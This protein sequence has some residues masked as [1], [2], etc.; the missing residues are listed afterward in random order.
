MKAIQGYES[1]IDKKGKLNIGEEII[2]KN[3]ILSK[4]LIRLIV[5]RVIVGNENIKIEILEKNQGESE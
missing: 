2:F 3:N 5:D 4:Q 1:I